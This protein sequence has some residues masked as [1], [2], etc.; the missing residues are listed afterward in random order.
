MVNDIALTCS[1]YICHQ[2]YFSRALIDSAFSRSIPVHSFLNVLSGLLLSLIPLM[3][4]IVMSF[5][6]QLYYSLVL[7]YTTY[8]EP[9]PQSSIGRLFEAVLCCGVSLLPCRL[10]KNSLENNT[11]NSGSKDISVPCILANYSHQL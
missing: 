11:L 3:V 4:T 7:E 1:I 6:Q 5:H 10:V 2:V 9:L 8:M